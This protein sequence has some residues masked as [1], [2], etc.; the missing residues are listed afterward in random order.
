MIG[1]RGNF[2]KSRKGSNPTSNYRKRDLRLPALDD[3][4]F[5]LRQPVQLVH[6]GVDLG[7][8]PL[9]LAGQV[10]AGGIRRVGEGDGANG[11]LAFSRKC[12]ISQWVQTWGLKV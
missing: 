12:V 1:S 2:S 4:D 11:K 8:Q 7:V 5:L 6:Q 10:V 9:D 3:G